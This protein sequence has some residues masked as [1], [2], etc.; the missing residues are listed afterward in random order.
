MLTQRLNE[1]DTILENPQ[2]FLT[3]EKKFENILTD[4]FQ[5]SDSAEYKKGMNKIRAKHKA[6]STNATMQGRG[7]AKSYGYAGDFEVI[8]K[9]Y[10]QHIN[11][12][13]NHRVW[14]EYFHRQTA[15]IA[16][17]NRKDYFKALMKQHKKVDSKTEVLNLA[18]G[19]CRDLKE[20]YE[21]DAS[22][23]NF[24]FDCVEL[25]INAIAYATTLV[26]D[27][28]NKVNF[29]NKNIF[30]FTPEKTYDIIWSAGLFD[31][32]DDKIFIKILKRLIDSNPN[33]KIVVGNF[34]ASNHN[35]PYMEIIGEW[36][37]NY[38]TPEQLRNLAI[39]AGANA[40]TIKIE[41]ESQGVNLFLHIN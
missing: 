37:L 40:D 1:L 25:D 29:I 33:S 16:V 22:H 39:A 28:I 17:R 34:D 13:E 11:D 2:D 41:S 20:F 10:T 4:L 8:D 35:L 9:I 7:Y 3:Y 14:D 31:Y 5:F 32:F 23:S 6:I 36:Y 15:P 26:G 24:Y 19:P 27:N 21:E 30:R 18:S 12:D 38:R